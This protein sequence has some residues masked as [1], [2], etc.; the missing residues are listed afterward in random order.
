[1]TSIEKKFSEKFQ[2]ALL[3]RLNDSS[4]SGDIAAGVLAR[5]TSS[6]KKMIFSLSGGLA[7][8]A[9]VVILLTFTIGENNISEPVYENFIA[10]QV[11]KTYIEAVKTQMI[12]KSENIFSNS[13]LS[14]ETDLLIS[15]TLSYR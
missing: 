9:A 5:R 8:A 4:W 10:D 12:V 14:N 13:V 2:R 6:R 15:E 3:S 1:M 7:A 11:G